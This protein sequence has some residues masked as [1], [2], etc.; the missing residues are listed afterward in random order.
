ML[1]YFNHIF[2]EKCISGNFLRK[3]SEHMP[4]VVIFNDLDPKIKNRNIM[5]KVTSLILMKRNSLSIDNDIHN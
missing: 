2:L 1:N 3:I 5:K 4:N